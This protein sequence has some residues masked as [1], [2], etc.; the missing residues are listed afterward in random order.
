MVNHSAF[1]LAFIKRS[2]FFFYVTHETRSAQWALLGTGPYSGQVPY[3]LIY[4][5]LNF[6][7]YT[8]ALFYHPIGLENLCVTTRDVEAEIFELLLLPP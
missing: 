8:V 1:I 7:I 5:P 2:E 3:S 6:D 4:L